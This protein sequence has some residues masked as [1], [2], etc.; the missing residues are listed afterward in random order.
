MPSLPVPLLS[1]CASTYYYYIKYYSLFNSYLYIYERGVREGWMGM[2]VGGGGG[3][4]RGR[5]KSEK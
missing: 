5:V 2:G 3:G 1:S 4:D